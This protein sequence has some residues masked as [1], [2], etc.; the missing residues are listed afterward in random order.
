MYVASVLN[1]WG[2]C[3]G[4]QRE[5]KQEVIM[6]IF[7]FQGNPQFVFESMDC[8]YLFIWENLYTCAHPVV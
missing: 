8:T 3:S 5:I 1:C 7:F 4:C 2:F 6:E